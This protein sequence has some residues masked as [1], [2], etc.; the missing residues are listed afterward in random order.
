[1]KFGFNESF[2]ITNE[3]GSECYTA[4]GN[5]VKMTIYDT[6]GKVVGVLD[7]GKTIARLAEI[8]EYTM[9]VNGAQVGTFSKKHKVIGSEYLF[10]GVPWT[11]DAVTDELK[12]GD[13]LLAKLKDAT[14][15]L[16][17]FLSFGPRKYDVDL[18]DDEN[19]VTILLVAFGWAY[20]EAQ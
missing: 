7:S 11:L 5:A 4:K 15:F 20:F 3:S 2:T 12:R 14:S 13:A 9:Y 17:H 8:R 6:S 1:M 16:L 18:T 10:D 19:T